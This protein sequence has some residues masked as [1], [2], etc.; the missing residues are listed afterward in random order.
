MDTAERSSET[1]MERR[2]LAMREL[3]EPLPG[4]S[5]HVHVAPRA[6]GQEEPTEEEEGGGK[7]EQ[8]P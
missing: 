7:M 5:A 2:R 6:E 8:G 4:Y 3:S 1:G